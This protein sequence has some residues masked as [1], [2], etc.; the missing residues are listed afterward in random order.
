LAATPAARWVSRH[1]NWKID[2]I[3]LRISGGRF[4]S[5]LM[6]P[7]ALLETTGARTGSVRRNP[8][9]YFHDDDVVTIVASNA[10]DAIHPAWLHNLRA[11][12]AV[13]FAGDK[14]TATIVEDE[15]ERRRL[16]ALADRVFPAF[17][18]YRRDADRHGRQIPI[19]Q[20]RPR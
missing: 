4:A 2:P 13:T 8:V 14:M 6:F 15:E 9:I 17:E 10:G 16:W 3:L 18:N 12:P 19:V 11:N 1:V 5:T 7:T 20:L